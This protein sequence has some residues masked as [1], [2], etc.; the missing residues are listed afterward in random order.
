MI[1]TPGE[2]VSVLKQD[3]FAFD[4]YS[5]IH[6]VIMGNEK[7]YKTMI[8]KDEIYQKEHFTEAD[9]MRAAELEAEFS[10]MGGW[11]AEAKASSY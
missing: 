6:T 3:H 5:V 1:V 9:G 11:E 8:E 10:E 7:L 4:E 2:R